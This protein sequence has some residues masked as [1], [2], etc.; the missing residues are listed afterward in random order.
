MPSY[1]ASVSTSSMLAWLDD[2][3][4]IQNGGNDSHFSHIIVGFHSALSIIY[5]I[6]IDKILL[7][8]FI[9]NKRLWRPSI[10]EI[11]IADFLKNTQ[12]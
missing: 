7:W 9:K 12:L 6:V 3:V 1:K 2:N 8:A 5:S 4:I 11:D 10:L